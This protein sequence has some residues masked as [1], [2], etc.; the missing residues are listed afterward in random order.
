MIKIIMNKIFKYSAISA[1]LLTLMMATSCKDYFADYYDASGTYS[2][3]TLLE[4]LASNPDYADYYRL[5]QAT[6]VDDTIR[7]YELNYLTVFVPK[8]G[9]IDMGKD[10]ETL[11]NL[12]LMHIVRDPVYQVNMN[13]VVLS[14]CNGRSLR[15]ISEGSSLTVNN[16]NILRFNERYAN[17]IIHQINSPIE[18][19][20]S[21]WEYL[22]SNPDYTK[23]V[24]YVNSCVSEEFLP[25]LSIPT[26]VY[27]ENNNMIY[28]DSVFETYNYYL[29]SYPIDNH[30]YH[31][32]LFV[33]EDAVVEDIFRN[34]FVDG[35]GG[36]PPEP[37]EPP[38]P[39]PDNPDLDDPVEPEPFPAR[40]DTLNF[41][42]RVYLHGVI[43]GKEY[44][45][46]Q[47]NPANLISVIG[48]KFN[49]A[50]SNI[51]ASDQLL[52]SNGLFA[53]VSYFD[54]ATKQFF[55]QKSVRLDI[56]SDTE[57]IFPEGWDP[58]PSMSN[59][60]PDPQYNGDILI[61]TYRRLDFGTFDSPLMPRYMTLPIHN[62]QKGRYTVQ[63]SYLT[64]YLGSNG[65]FG[66]G[67]VQF[68]IR[69]QGGGAVE[70]KLVDPRWLRPNVREDEDM[71]EIHVS[72]FG[73]V[74]LDFVS[75][76][77]GNNNSYM[78]YIRNI[79]LQPVQ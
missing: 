12:A 17:G 20:I 62:V 78:L 70:E 45:P 53:G 41:L 2:Q 15:F 47:W 75:V 46:S 16:V 49:P 61:F 43:M 1:L 33:P 24:E 13:N 79:N 48:S 40:S 32:T 29:R 65:N 72:D 22:C 28:T 30:Q 58:A 18:Y 74:Y 63:L 10:L 59:Y 6:G 73:D 7:L 76:A 77:P 71:M 55:I 37:P 69:R 19:M 52:F 66:N 11:R 27:D 67:C 35:L 38:E 68:R 23:Y 25:E 8:N 64:M 4:I 5:L 42:S 26:G 31:F 34:Y 60:T 50:A 14:S 51:N 21:L 39:D 36:W 56:D 57:V 3:E 44:R 9:T 54:N